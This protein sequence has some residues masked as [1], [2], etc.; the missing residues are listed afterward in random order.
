M[1]IEEWFKTRRVSSGTWVIDD[2]G[3]DIMYLISGDKKCLLMDTGW[4]I[5]DLPKLVSSFTSLPLM[6]MNTHGHP[7]HTY[8]NSAFKQIH[9]H[10]ADKYFIDKPSSAE[11]KK[12]IMENV[13]PKPLPENFNPDAWAVK[14]PSIKTIKDGYVFDLGNRHLQ[15]V[16]VPGHTPGSVC[17]LDRENRLLFTGDTIQNPTW[18]HLQES[19]PLSQFHKNLMQLQS[20]MDEFDYFLPGHANLETLPLPKQNINELVAG[21]EQILKEKQV[22]R[23]EKTFAGDGLRCDFGSTGIVYRPNHL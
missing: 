11:S 19:L 23:E 21:I 12:W 1:K 14:I 15:T 8:G 18:L 3:S 2:R 5:G 22:G 13:L 17:L 7:D 9:I 10:E 6:V 4:G 20:R 16:C